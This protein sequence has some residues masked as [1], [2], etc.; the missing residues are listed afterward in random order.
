MASDCGE[1]DWHIQAL[2]VVHR[3]LNNSEGHFP[4]EC[5]STARAC[6]R[7]CAEHG[8]LLFQRKTV[9]SCSVGILIH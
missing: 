3:F 2:A 4:T 1:S 5:T 6:E 9:Q 8:L 7:S